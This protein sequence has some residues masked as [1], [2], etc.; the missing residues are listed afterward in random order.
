MDDYMNVSS[1]DKARGKRWWRRERLVAVSL[2]KKDTRGRLQ[3]LQDSG[4]PRE[5]ID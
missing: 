1:A 5:K 3:S 2:Y 4:R